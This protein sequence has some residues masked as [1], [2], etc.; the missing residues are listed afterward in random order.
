MENTSYIGLSRQIALGRQLDMVA[1][2]VANM[3]SSGF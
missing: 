3:N 1:N 2:N